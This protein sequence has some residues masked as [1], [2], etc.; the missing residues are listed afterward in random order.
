MAV[1]SSEVQYSVTGGNGATEADYTAPAGVLTIPAGTRQGSIVIQTTADDV[2]DRGETLMVTLTCR[3][4]FGC[5]SRSGN[6][7]PGHHDDR[8][9]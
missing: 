8:G 9:Q 6:A 7:E 1:G 2:L 3:H 4:Q 5:G